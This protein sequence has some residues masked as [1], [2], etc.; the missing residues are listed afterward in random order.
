MR[1]GGGLAL[2]AVLTALALPSTAVAGH[3]LQQLMDH[4]AP[5]VGSPAPPSPA[6]QSGGTDAKW[7]LVGTI[8][9]GNP[10][11]D[12]DFFT[13]GGNTYASVGTL[14]IGG[15]GGGQ[16]IIQLTDG[17]DVEPKFL[18]AAP[19]ATCLSN[20]SA[21][22]GLQHDVEAT[23]KGNAILNTD[24]LGAARNDTQLLIDATDQRGRCHD[25]GTLGLAGAP[26]GGLEILDITDPGNPVTIGLTSHIGEAHTVNVDPRRPHI[27]YAVTS[28]GIAV[29]A[30]GQRN[31]E[32]ETI[33]SGPEAGQ[34]NPDRFDLDGFEVVDLSSCMN[35]APGTSIDDKRARCR[36]QVFRYRYPNTD[37][38]LGHTRTSGDNALYA[39]HE[40]EVYPNDR[41]TCA[42]GQAMI[43]FDM[44]GAFDN[45]GTPGNFRD[46]KPRGTPLP[47]RERPSSSTPPFDT[48]A[49]VIDCVDGQ[50]EGTEDL[51]V[52]KWLGSG[53]PSLQGVNWLG[54]AF[55]QGRGAGGA[56][57]PSFDSTQDI[58]FD[59]EAELSHSGRYVFATDERGGGVQPPGAACS[60]G[61][62][63]KTGNGGIHAYRTSALLR[64]RPSTTDE[65]FSSYALTPEGGRAIY[66]AP[67]RTQPQPSLCT[68]HVFQ[69]V[70]GQ[71]RIFM[72]WY[73]QGTE[74]LDYVEHENGRLEWRETGYFIPAQ[75][76]EWVSHIFKAR[77]NRD[78]SWTYWG[79]TG[80]FS[81]AADGRNAI[82]IFKVTLP[83]PP[84]PRGLM[85]GVG[86]GFNP[87]LCVPAPARASSGRVSAARIG[88]RARR[89]RR[90]YLVMRRRGR[91]TRHCVRGRRGRF[92]IASGRSGKIN[93]AATTSR[94]IGTKRIRPGRRL[95]SARVA[96]VRRLAPAR[97]ALRNVFIGTYSRHRKFIYGTRGR[98]VTFIGSVSRGQAR[99]VR[100]LARRLR[101]ARLVPR[102]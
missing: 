15:N 13:Q 87:R 69:Q 25:Q 6:F 29:S 45:N 12:V 53:G 90:R 60:P 57:T 85:S 89:F 34:P 32:N 17:E 2:A 55:H 3:G 61:V 1:K 80:D 44:R 59:H 99:S 50:G 8:P 91:L 65:A 94:R 66:R 41:L 9:T 92:Y 102:R 98:R 40:L 42:S 58:D 79:A 26:R 84:A 93:F 16:T 46:D 73:S 74:V 27:A 51:S 31:N 70:P 82:D 54:S 81:L 35:F 75:A 100:S 38:S 10:H 39:C 56:A 49:T 63:N 68:A 71:N 95:P 14:A 86:P 11:T 88:N 7:E 20:P 96:G 21:A 36:P 43:Q 52:P 64:R 47:C 77:R 4:P 24:V 28:D 83:P 22:L 37:I 5:A 72:G 62:D 19:T 97:R 30:E 101:A 78:D 33:Q 48:K 23:P 76:N 67:I 18:G